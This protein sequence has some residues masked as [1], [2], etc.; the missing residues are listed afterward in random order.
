MV[1]TG[2]KLA[3][4]AALSVAL[5]AGTVGVA[6]AGKKKVESEV[7]ITGGGPN[8]M[9]GTVDADKRECRLNR[10]VF[11]YVG[12]SDGR[13]VLI[14][15]DRTNRLGRWSI[16]KPIYAGDY[17]IKVRR[18]RRGPFICQPDR[19]PTRRL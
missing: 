11:A 15:T 8:G 10:E 4:V 3:L 7:E 12:T 14:G 5:L 13:G 16:K 19:S 6:A 9:R 18:D 2:A 17:F 1:V